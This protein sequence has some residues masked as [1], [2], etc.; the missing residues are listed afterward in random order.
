MH[1]L[2]RSSHWHAGEIELT[3]CGLCRIAHD[4]L[5]DGRDRSTP[6]RPSAVARNHRDHSVP[7]LDYTDATAA[8]T[9]TVP[10]KISLQLWQL[11]CVLAPFCVFCFAF[12]FAPEY[13]KLDTGGH[14]VQ[15]ETSET[16]FRDLAACPPFGPVQRLYE[17]ALRLE[18]F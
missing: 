3:M 4:V 11:A 14:V 9:S 8:T 18:E 7:G 10:G 5:H 15:D 16:S 6:R 2:A 1:R 12:F 13:Q 17:A